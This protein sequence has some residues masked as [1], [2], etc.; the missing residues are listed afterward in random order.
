MGRIKMYMSP[1]PLKRGAQHKQSPHHNHPHP[2]KNKNNLDKKHAVCASPLTSI[3]SWY[4]IASYASKGTRFTGPAPSSSVCWLL[5]PCRHRRLVPGG[6][7]G[8]GAAVGGSNMEVA[9]RRGG[10]ALQ[11]Q[12][13]MIGV[14][15]A[16]RH[17]GMDR[18]YET[19]YIRTAD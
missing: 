8:I 5:A 9:W 19:T 10:G 3:P 7:E 11:T 4:V 14:P 6:G 16:R 2:K 15:H 18:Q 12:Q 13:G 17:V 1:K